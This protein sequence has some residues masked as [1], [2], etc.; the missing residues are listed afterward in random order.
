[1]KVSKN[2]NTI[3]IENNVYKVKEVT[4]EEKINYPTLCNICDLY[5]IHC[6]EAPCEQSNRWDN[7][8]IVFKFSHKIAK[9]Y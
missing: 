7:K 6:K 9:I 8:E 5:N 3:I 1:M 2:Q 4:E